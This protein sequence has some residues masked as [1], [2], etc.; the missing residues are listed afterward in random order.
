MLNYYKEKFT[1]TWYYDGEYESLCE[2]S[3]NSMNVHAY[4]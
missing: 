4:F 3:A 2:Y 1:V